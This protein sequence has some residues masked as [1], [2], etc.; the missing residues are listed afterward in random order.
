KTRVDDPGDPVFLGDGSFLGRSARSGWRQPSHSAEGGTPPGQVTD[1]GR[2]VRAVRMAADKAGQGFLS[3]ARDRAMG[4]AGDRG[5]ATG[6]AATSTATAS[7]RN[8]R[9]FRTA[10]EVAHLG[11]STSRLRRRHN[12]R[13]RKVLSRRLGG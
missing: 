4:C 1:G 6:S 5:T 11:G 2:A 12:E 8:F 9:D 7:S 3:G 13:H 10:L